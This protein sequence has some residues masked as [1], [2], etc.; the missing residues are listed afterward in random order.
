MP[1]VPKV[2]DNIENFQ[3]VNG[4]GARYPLGNLFICTQ[5]NKPGEIFDYILLS[6]SV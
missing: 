5:V 1:K 6:H 4:S 3:T 2:K